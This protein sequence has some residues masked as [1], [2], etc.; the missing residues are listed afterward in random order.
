MSD[1]KNTST[2]LYPPGSLGEQLIEYFHDDA[3]RDVLLRQLKK[4]FGELSEATVARVNAADST[5]L[6]TWL[7]RILTAAI[8]EDVLEDA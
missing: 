7:E 4:R 2:P 5:T 6:D 3:C 1:K 8:L